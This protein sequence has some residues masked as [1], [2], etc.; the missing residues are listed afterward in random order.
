MINN[1][2]MSETTQLPPDAQLFQAFTGFMVSR[3]VSAV[4]ELG[5]SRVIMQAL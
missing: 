4:A 3:S 5:F 2:R 1:L